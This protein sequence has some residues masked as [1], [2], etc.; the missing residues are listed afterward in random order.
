[1]TKT[2][3]RCKRE[4]SIEHFHKQS[5]KKDG[6]HSHCRECRKDSRQEKKAKTGIPRECKL[7]RKVF[8]ATAYAVSHGGGKYCSQECARKMVMNGCVYAPQRLMEGKNN[9]NYKGG[10]SKNNYRYKL[11]Q[12]E[13]YPERVKARSKVQDA[14]RR[15]KLIRK[16]C[17]RCG[18]KI[19]IQAH[20]PDY[21]KPLLVVWLCA[22]CHRKL[23]FKEKQS[24]K[25]A[26]DS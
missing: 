11:L 6:R 8:M 20:H 2:C 12:V 9:P 1:M 23:H 25:E 24:R 7:C 21:S 4:L 22:D 18:S 15:N 3:K 16:P 19:N 13:R 26:T 17:Q 10:I 5:D 14:I